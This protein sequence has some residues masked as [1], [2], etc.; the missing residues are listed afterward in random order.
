MIA[1]S[2]YSARLAPGAEV[3]TDLQ[4]IGEEGGG[5]R[6][7]DVGAGSPLTAA[8][9]DGTVPGLDLRLMSAAEPWPLAR[10]Y[11]CVVVDTTGS[12]R[13]VT[14]AFCLPLDARG[15]TWWDGPQHSRLIE[16][17]QSFSNLTED[18]YGARL[19]ASRYP[20]AVL[21]DGNRALCLAVPLEP[22]R[23]VRFL[24]DP[25]ALEL[26]AE[27]DFGLSPIP[28]RFP[29]CADAAV[30]AFEVPARWAFRR[31]LERY[32][33]LHREVLER[34]AASGG[35]LLTKSPIRSVQSP[36]DFF[37]TWHDLPKEALN[38]VV[39]DADYGVAS[40]LYREPQTHWYPLK[41]DGADPMQDGPKRTYASFF[42]QLEADAKEGDLE[43]RSTLVSGV[44]RSDGRYD[45]Y[46]DEIAW[47]SLA[48]FGVNPAPD[49][50]NTGFERW[51]NKAQFEFGILQ[52][53][54]GWNGASTGLAGVFL[55]SMEGWGNL[56]N[57]RK[58][59]WKTTEF[60][61]TFDRTNANR[62]SL[63]NIWGIRSFARALSQR[64][65]Q[66]KQLLMGNNAFYHTWFHMP[67]VDI[68]GQ[69]VDHH[70]SDETYLF[71]RS[72]AG[73]RP[74]WTL[75][76][77]TYDDR[78]RIEA[79]FR[80][81]LFY[82]IFPSMFHLHDGKSP[83]YWATPA[84]YER[85]RPLF[86]KYVPLIRRLDDAGWEPVPYAS[87]QPDSIRIERFGN[88]ATND[89]AFTLL[90]P[91]PE[92]RQVV[93]ELFLSDLGVIAIESASEWITG[94]PLALEGPETPSHRLV[95]TLSANGCAV[96]G[97]KTRR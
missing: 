81:S 79:Y 47:T 96:A 89:L 46:L 97:L 19:M 12:E 27:F 88:A 68:A 57:Y 92:P 61:L 21:D 37:F 39:A 70:V 18:Y 33:E 4:R 45:L 42:R 62:V 93:V 63:L 29:S 50:P 73:R 35:T 83:W 72:M 76:N 30:L 75:L 91:A 11:S 94:E 53:L 52:E 55:D 5:W 23:A 67:L 15:W 65:R 31:A 71:F 32:Y 25:A 82:G 2:L 95:L 28:Q 34:R 80:R 6:V 44:V 87:V 66:H 59:H 8:Q 20:L 43:S 49:V 78:A 22:A 3:G 7:A 90:N 16:G 69:E 1:V 51:P 10:K 86:K 38:D 84:Y 77:D 58:E 54:L 85:D 56:M 40:F 48:P 14:L 36:E 64:L 41:N 60:P 17:E 26:R 9:E 24:Y 74:F 13:A